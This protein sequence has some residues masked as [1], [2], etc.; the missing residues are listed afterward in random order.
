MRTHVSWSVLCIGLGAA[1]CAPAHVSAAPMGQ[2]RTEPTSC[3][4]NK[5]A[6]TTVY[7]STQLSE[8]PVPRSV[9]EVVYPEEAKKNKSQGR[10][11]VSAVVTADGTVDSASVAVT[12]RV[13]P[14]LDAE[15][16]RVVTLATFW[17]GCRDKV[18]VRT[19]LTFPFD[20]HAKASNAG[21]AFGVLVGVW[22]GVMAVMMD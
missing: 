6:D 9:P 10:V 12:M 22:A 20:F 13:Q 8:Q 5:S 14:L 3:A 19:R 17:P 16:K 7:E 18:A 1:G 11:L 21:V 4:S 15:A 2:V